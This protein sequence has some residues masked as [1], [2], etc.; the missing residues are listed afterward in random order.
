MWAIYGRIITCIGRSTQVDAYEQS[1]EWDD[2]DAFLGSKK[3]LF[4]NALVQE[5]QQLLS[6]LRLSFFCSKEGILKQDHLNR[7]EKIENTLLSLNNISTYK[8]FVLFKNRYAKAEGNLI[9][10]IEIENGGLAWL[11]RDLT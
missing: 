8:Q 5:K 10:R 4:Q 7:I 6:C 3:A 9:Q 11:L 1:L 2:K